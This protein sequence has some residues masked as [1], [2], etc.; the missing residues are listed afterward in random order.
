MGGWCNCRGFVYNDVFVAIVIEPYLDR[1][2][3]P[4]MTQN[5]RN[6]LKSAGVLAGSA[7]FATNQSVLSPQAAAQTA[8]ASG[9]IEVFINQYT[10]GTFYAREGI[11]LMQNLDRC[12]AELKEAGVAGFEA[13]GN[14]PEDLDVYIAALKKQDMQL[15]SIYTSP[16]LHDESTAESEIKRIIAVAERAKAAGTKIVV[17][18]PQAKGGKSDAELNRQNQSLDILGAALRKLD[19]KLAMHYHTTELEFAAREFHSFMCDTSPENVWL[20]F[21]VHWS[22]RASGNSAVSAY[23]HAI[24]YG[25]R[26]AELHLRQSEGGTWTETFVAKA[27]IDYDKTFAILRRSKAFGDCHVVLEQAPENGTPKTLKP[28]DIFKKS[29]EAVKEMYS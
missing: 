28:L 21:D 22:F 29:V 17:A 4:T 25:D 7:M 9:P 19:M 8:R 11:D 12:F 26:V 23:N 6:F 14:Q 2:K 13:M 3:E 18:N 20:C 10:V 5:R 1:K 24:L 27:D 16:N 15:R